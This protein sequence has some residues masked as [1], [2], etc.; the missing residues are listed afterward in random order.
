MNDS[1]NTA[2]ETFAVYLAKHYIGRKGFSAGAVPEAAALAEACDIVLTLIDGMTMQVI[3]IVDR[4]THPQKIFGLSHEVLD[5][6]GKQCLKYSGEVNGTKMPVTFQIM[7]VGA[8][9][10]TAEDRLR[11]GALKRES[12]FSK[13]ILRSWKVDTTAGTAWTNAPFG[14][15][16]AKRSIERLLRTPRA[17]DAELRQ[18]E[19]ALSRERFPLLT[20]ALLVV[21]VALFGCELIYGVG[22]WSGLLAPSIQTLVAL[23]GLN[24]TLVLQSGEWY[25][26]FSATL[27]HADALH[28]ALNGF[29][30]Y[31]AGI[32]LES[33]VGR[34]WFFA[35][36]VVGGVCGSLMSL[37]VNPDSVVSVGASGAI[38]GLLAAAFVCSFRHSL[39]ALRMQVQMTT[40]QILIPSLLPLAVSRT[41]QHID[42]AGHLGGVLSGALVGLALLKTWSPA[43]PRPA[44][45]PAAVA[46]CVAGTL[47]LALSFLPLIRDYHTHTLDTLLI[48][49]EQLPKSNTEAKT[50]AADLIAR[51]PRDPRARLYQASGLIDRNDLPGAERELRVGLAEKEILT[52][53]FNPELEAHLKG[54]LA[55][56]LSDRNQRTEAKAVAQP[57]CGTTTATLAPIRDMLIKAEL[58]ER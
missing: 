36:F 13:I 15:F 17:V 35:L 51:Y 41:G 24:K 29:C 30:L 52:T 3:C 20:V 46:L 37:A 11:L 1:N 14:G 53:K 31:L 22:S 8:G 44:F 16:L 18:P 55:L 54:M 49:N 34:R 12:L 40:L 6:I 45:L 21:L 4:E 9:P 56:V 2:G 27:L 23:G 50:K 32:M 48:P 28:L 25:R 10:V 33:F 42:F 19:I 58:C 47:A 7:E 5:Q 38:M 57:A 39:G 43:K 26:I